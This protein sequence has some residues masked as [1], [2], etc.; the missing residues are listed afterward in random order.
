MNKT[1]DL[2]KF[3]ILGMF[4]LD[5][6]IGVEKLVS[7][8]ENGKF[9]SRK[10]SYYKQFSF[11]KCSELREHM[12]GLL[13][14]QTDQQKLFVIYENMLNLSAKVFYKTLQ[15]E[16]CKD[17]ESYK[18]AKACFENDCYNLLAVILDKPLMADKFVLPK[19]DELI[20]AR[21]IELDNKSLL[22]T[23]CS[24][25][26][27]DKNQ[28]ILLT[29]MGG[30]YLA[31]FTKIM[32][33]CDYGIAPL[34]AYAG[35]KDL[36]ENDELEIKNYLDNPAIL[37]SKDILFL[38]DNVGTGDTMKEIKHL[39]SKEGIDLK[40]GAV[41]YNWINYHKVEIGEKDINR[42]NTKEIEYVTPFNY[43]GNKLLKH[44]IDLH[45]CA[46]AD[47][48]VEYIKSKSYLAE[49]ISDIDALQKKGERYAEACGITFD[50]NG[51]MNKNSVEFY[52]N[53]TSA[54]AILTTERKIEF[55][56][57]LIKPKSVLTDSV[58]D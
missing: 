26:N 13:K 48:Y 44:A 8:L 41:Q 16:G 35:A 5:D 4:Q 33:G 15:K 22:L 20:D 11:T 12:K 57:D 34:S 28:N 39:L 55:N 1:L 49:G 56:K 27:L 24:Q 32:Y 53:L 2:S 23:F 42:F 51:L 10:Y 47:E 30:I 31:P 52:K 46:S 25:L 18:Q 3:D 58:R 14:G 29:G 7:P 50:E 36:L 17:T 19:S 38:D 21:Q 9:L 37:K 54:V 6:N 43:P 45:L 40:C